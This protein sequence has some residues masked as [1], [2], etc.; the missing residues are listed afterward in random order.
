MQMSYILRLLL[1]PA[2]ASAL[3][4]FSGVASADPPGKPAPVGTVLGTDAASKK[5]AQ[6]RKGTAQGAPPAAQPVVRPPAATATPAPAPAVMPAPIR[7]TPPGRTSTPATP[8]PPDKP[9]LSRDLEAQQKFEQEVFPRAIPARL[10]PGRVKLEGVVPPRK[11]PRPGAEYPPPGLRSESH[12]AEKPRPG[13]RRKGAA[14]KKSGMKKTVAPPVAWLSKLALPDI[15]VR[16]DPKVIRFLEFYRHSPRGRAIMSHWLKRMGRYQKLMSR[17]CKKYGVPQALIYVSMVESGFS[18]L[19]TSRVGAAGLWQFMPGPGRWFGLHRD[20]W[21]DERRNPDLATEAGVKMLKHLYTRFKSWEL[22]LAAYN[23]GHGA[24]IK[25]MQKYNTNDYW[26]LC[27]YEAGLPWGTTIY[28]PKIMALAIVGSNRAYFGYGNVKPEPE[29]TFDVVAVSTSV[30]MAQAARAAGATTKH[31]VL[32]NPELRRGRTPP[33]VKSWIRVPR[34]SKNRFYA[35]LFR[36]KGELAKY[37]PYLVRLGETDASI[38]Q[39]HGISQKQLRRINKLRSAFEIRPGLTILVPARAL[40]KPALVAKKRPRPRKGKKKSG[41]K[42]KEA[43]QDE[44]ILVA[45]P[46]HA[47]TKVP[48]RKRVFYRVVLGDTLPRV[49]ATFGVNELQL[50]HWNGLNPS[51]RL[52][53]RMILQVFVGKRF[54]PQKVVLQDPKKLKIMKAGSAEFLNYFEKRKDRR[55]L[56]YTVRKGDT[57]KSVGRRFGLTVGDVI[58]IN[59]ISRW[60]K[61]TKGQKLVVY[62]EEERL[63]KA[64][65]KARK[66]GKVKAGIKG[67][68]E[69]VKGKKRGKRVATVKRKLAVKRKPVAK[70]VVKPGAKKATRPLKASVKPKVKAQGKKANRKKPKTRRKKPRASSKAK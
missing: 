53:S 48:G 22:A 34:G 66:K 51:A 11:R 37:K 70:A 35:G 69:R 64:R 19:T 36:I 50:A 17:T 59:N 4:F 28:V 42:G 44:P 21:V 12:G 55:R 41:V 26:R 46:P 20:Y 9:S 24:V 1:P 45:V 2:L 13:R 15:P 67:K 40:R 23:A 61:L 63:R 32:L 60:S 52:V 29:L 62:V 6:P 43:E 39:R 30:T 65:R 7:Q 3:I 33:R 25:A 68:V 18:P 16:W 56:S 54:N 38:A 8:L 47:P 31:M 5:Q 49:A 14:K 57:L 58:R 10:R 27:S